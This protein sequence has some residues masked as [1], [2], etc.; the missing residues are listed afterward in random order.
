ME[1]PDDHLVAQSLRLD[2]DLCVKRRD[3]VEDV[4][5]KQVLAAVNAKAS[6]AP[7][8]IEPHIQSAF[9]IQIHCPKGLHTLALSAR[10]AGVVSSLHCADQ[11]LLA[12]PQ[13]VEPNE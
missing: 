5:L 9:C 1:Q 3:R 12:R 6:V 7:I 2:I 8:S 11:S 4:F 10:A 13:S